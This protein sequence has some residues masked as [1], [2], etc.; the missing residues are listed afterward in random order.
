MCFYWHNKGDKRRNPFEIPYSCAECNFF[1][2][3]SNEAH[4]C[5]E[6]DLCLKT[7]N[8]TERMFHPEVW[9]IQLCQKG[10]NGASCNRGLYCAFGHSAED[11]RIPFSQEQAKE[12]KQ[13]QQA[14]TSSVPSVILGGGRGV[15]SSPSAVAAAAAATAAIATTSNTA[16]SASVACSP[17]GASPA[18]MNV[19]Q[20]LVRKLLVL[21]K[22]A[23]PDGLPV[24][25]MPKRFLEFFGERIQDYFPSASS[26]DEAK[27]KSRIKELLLADGGAKQI[28]YRGVQPRYVYDES[29]DLAAQERRRLN[30]QKAETSAQSAVTVASLSGAQSQSLISTDND[31]VNS[32]VVIESGMNGM[33]LGSMG[34]V[35]GF[36][37][38]P[39]ISY[40]VHLGG[41]DALGVVG[42]GWFNAA[43]VGVG[44]LA[45]ESMGLGGVVGDI[46]QCSMRLNLGSMNTGMAMG[47]GMDL[48]G[49]GT[50][51]PSPFITGTQ[52][53]FGTSLHHQLQYHHQ[54]Q[55]QQSQQYQQYQPQHFDAFTGE[56]MT[57]TGLG[58]GVCRSGFFNGPS[59]HNSGGSNGSYQGNENVA[60]VGRANCSVVGS[61]VGI[62][63]NHL[64]SGSGSAI[65]GLNSLNVGMST[66]MG[67]G[68][69]GVPIGL[70]RGSG[71]FVSAKG[72][73]SSLATFSGSTIDSM[74][75]S[76]AGR[77]RGPE[78]SSTP[79]I[80]PAVAGLTGSAQSTTL[81]KTSVASIE[82]TATEADVRGV[83]REGDKKVAITLREED[84]GF[85]RLSEKD[86][87]RELEEKKRLNSEVEKLKLTVQ[88]LKGEAE[89]AAKDRLVGAKEIIALKAA[90]ES[91]KE[92]LT[93]KLRQFKSKECDVASQRK[94]IDERDSTLRR[95][96]EREI[97]A[98][99]A[100]IIALETDAALHKAS[101]EQYT[102]QLAASKT[103]VAELFTEMA[104]LQA[105]LAEK[106]EAFALDREDLIMEIADLLD[107][108]ASTREFMSKF[109]A[110][111]KLSENPEIPKLMELYEQKFG[112]D[113]TWDNLVDDIS[114]GGVVIDSE[115]SLEKDKERKLKLL[116]ARYTTKG[117]LLGAEA[118][119]AV[120]TSTTAGRERN[121]TG[122]AAASPYT[123]LKGVA[124]G[125]VAE[126]AAYMGGAVSIK[127]ANSSTDIC[128]L[129]GC[130][131]E[132]AFVCGK[133][134]AVRYCGPGHQRYV[135]S[136]C[137]SRSSI[138][139][140]LTIP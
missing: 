23:G 61:G 50:N 2:N 58:L 105:S 101:V 82:P 46:N 140:L 3:S 21:L 126:T 6:G 132:G 25:E 111:A 54:I 81:I 70:G 128:A 8:I 31:N 104:I 123:S 35:G 136:W 30:A 55:L 16:P 67:L 106:S 73:S 10:Q 80:Q 5:P 11:H 116:M 33:G 69:F 99:R 20:E 91:V 26:P 44:G 109:L 118:K 32:G 42:G 90:N 92:E 39:G 52:Q 37:P 79:M 34:P 138:N 87:H 40:G 98:L 89:K 115:E 72:T 127:T 64:G 60:V 4:D 18:P 108:A 19:S 9:K 27:V 17:G 7:H 96:N 12:K 29:G 63:S 41:S 45:S 14:A 122:L 22:P 83:I 43:G 59:G 93:I 134:N 24:Y 103:E 139:L 110:V 51:S 129:T 76:T 47:G 65:A 78:S 1:H 95:L 120:A 49:M 124:A 125:T 102:V 131:A 62:D 48:V 114:G 75:S 66:G 85:V 15:S 121:H 38:L 68:T 53:L 137:L 112:P 135:C 107:Q 57:G 113:G 97:P 84:K 130:S 117:P 56:P 94:I 28:M 71:D 13:A 86:R 119:P 36:G 77:R 88:S 74:T 100:R 133:C